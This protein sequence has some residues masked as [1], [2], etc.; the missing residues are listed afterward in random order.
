M[1]EKNINHL[2]IIM[3]G[4]GRWAKQRSAP[5]TFGHKKGVDAVRASV[6]GAIKNGIR[7]L[8]L[9]AFSYENW[10]RPEEE[11]SYL[12]DLFDFYIVSE[13]ETLNKENVRLRFIGE[14]D[15]LKPS[16]VEKIKKAEETTK[17][18]DTLTLFIAISYG[19]KKE[20]LQAVNKAIKDGCT[21]ITE[22]IIDKNLY[23]YDAPPPDMVVRT[24]GEQ[25]LSNFLLWQIAY[26]EF[27]FIEKYWPEVNE[28]DI[29]LIND[30]Y[31]KRNRRYG[32]V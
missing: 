18:N 29:T 6:K 11:V 28:D 24:S 14:L 20:I 25:R 7:F 23:T 19:S 9:Y 5:R 22:E 31:K 17:N 15:M 26:S 32:K 1:Q 27:L 12:M 2:A 10:Q 13:L 16:I 30:E 3:D 21:E 4:N 8:T